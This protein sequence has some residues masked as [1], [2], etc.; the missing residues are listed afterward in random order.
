M[1]KK[2]AELVNANPSKLRP[3]PAKSNL[4]PFLIIGLGIGLLVVGLIGGYIWFTRVQVE[5]DAKGVN[6]YKNLDRGHSSKPVSYPQR[7]PVGGTHNPTIQNCG[8]Y[9]KPVEDSNAVHSL[10][11]GAVWITY[12]P[13]LG[14]SQIEEL[15]SLVKGKR[16]ALLSP[17]PGQS[18]PVVVTAWGAQLTLP[19]PGDSRLGEFINTYLA[20]P[21]APEPGAPCNGGKGNPLDLNG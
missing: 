19:N 20:S 14:A 10:E 7:P 11:H 2:P 3:A 12:S 6:I 4:L 9:D 15:R 18:S 13:D 1:N 5:V 17:Y 21:N 8:I 16:Y